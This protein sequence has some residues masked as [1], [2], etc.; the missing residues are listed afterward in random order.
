MTGKVEIVPH[1]GPIRIRVSG[2]EP[3]KARVASVPITVKV[4]GTPGPAGPQG[5]PGPQGVPGPPG[6]LDTGIILDGG[7]F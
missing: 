7:N 5:D 1:T 6:H 3:I 4:L 2:T